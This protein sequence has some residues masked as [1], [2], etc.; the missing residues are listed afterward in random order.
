MPNSIRLSGRVV[1]FFVV[2]VG[3][4]WMV[5]P[6]VAAPATP[7]VPSNALGRFVGY[8]TIGRPHSISAEWRVPSISDSS[9]AHASTWIGLQSE[10]GAFIQ[11]GTL[12]DSFPGYIKSVPLGIAEK[13]PQ[14]IIYSGFWSGDAELFH[15]KSTFSEPV[16][17]GDLIAASISKTKRCWRLQLVDTRDQARFVRTIK[18]VNAVLTE[19]EWIQEDPTN[20]ATDGPLPYP[21][22]SQVRL[23]KVKLNG[24]PPSIDLANE[25]WMSVPGRDFA[26]TS[27]AGDGFQIVPVR[28]DAVQTRWVTARV[29]YEQAAYR[30]DIKQGTW[31]THPPMSTTATADLRPFLQR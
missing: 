15:P 6:Q 11:V 3:A 28:L 1:L 30:F 13:I 22:L 10:S 31:R 29:R 23:T 17:P 24:R 7:T 18:M 20:L 14:R 5:G 8:T 9:E 27:L 25:S 12:E 16:L 19:A 21:H 4:A 26:P 2:L